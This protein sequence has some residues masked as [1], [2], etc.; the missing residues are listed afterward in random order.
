[1]GLPAYAQEGAL[2]KSR[3]REEQGGVGRSREEE[4]IRMLRNRIVG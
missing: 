2:R 1:M 3:Y 4:I